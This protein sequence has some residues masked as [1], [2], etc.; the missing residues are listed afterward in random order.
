MSG[1]RTK[2]QELLV[3]LECIFNPRLHNYDIRQK[4]LCNPVGTVLKQ[5]TLELFQKQLFMV[6]LKMITFVLRIY[7]HKYGFIE[8]HRIVDQSSP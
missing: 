6:C 2:Q 8:I 5:R 3:F 4:I 7:L 1:N